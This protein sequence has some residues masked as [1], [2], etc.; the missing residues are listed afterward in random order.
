[1]KSPAR[2]RMDRPPPLHNTAPNDE[3][4]ILTLR[5]APDRHGRTGTHRLRGALKMLLRC[6]AL[7]C[8]RIEAIPAAP[9]ASD[10]AD[11]AIRPLPARQRANG[12]EPAA[13]R[14]ACGVREH[15]PDP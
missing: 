7:R 15:R 1:M 6:F 10:S 14:C 5:L 8:E 13:V 4:F 11:P 2:A 12:V 9:D 3:R